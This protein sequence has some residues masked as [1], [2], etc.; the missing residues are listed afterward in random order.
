M[1]PR[2]PRPSAG[3]GSGARFLG[4]ERDELDR[5][6]DLLSRHA[7]S[8]PIFD[9]LCR[10]LSGQARARPGAMLDVPYGDDGEMVMDLHPAG[11]DSAPLIV[12]LQGR[13]WRTDERA[14]SSYPAM[15]LAPHAA[16]LAVVGHGS[17]PSTSLSVMVER[18]C[19]AVLWL[20][21]NAARLNADPA[22]IVLLGLG[23]GSHVAAMTLTA[24]WPR[25][26]GIED[27]A[28]PVSAVAALSGIYDLEPVRLS[29]LNLGLELD[30]AA[31]AQLS[32][33][34]LVP[35]LPQPAP[36]MLLAVGERETDEYHRHMASYARAL[37]A[38]GVA[39]EAATIPGHHHFSLAA[40]LANPA[41]AIT[42]RV[43]GLTGSAARSEID[44]I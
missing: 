33:L 43:I 10:T 6:Y 34:R 3:T 22:R 35:A 14:D 5:Q 23:S 8:L 1:L 15:G 25:L 38:H 21:D 18:A 30:A 13:Y 32:P 19:R 12:I 2:R 37:E 31:V 4:Y 36:R 42:N 26:S 16:A 20:R 40:E 17:L 39:V 41:S 27:A 9:G 28:C 11:R 7:D 44:T 29:F 24:D